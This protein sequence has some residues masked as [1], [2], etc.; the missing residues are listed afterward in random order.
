VRAVNTEAAFGNLNRIGKKY[1]DIDLQKPN[2]TFECNAYEGFRDFI[3]YGFYRNRKEELA[4]RYILHAQEALDKIAPSLPDDPTERVKRLFGRG[5]ELQKQFNN[6]ARK[7]KD[8]HELDRVF[9][10][11]ACDLFIEKLKNDGYNVR[12]FCKRSIEAHELP[13]LHRKLMEIKG[14]GP[15]I[16]SL[17]LRDILLLYSRSRSEPEKFLNELTAE[18]IRAVYPIDTWVGK[19]SKRILDCDGDE[20]QVAETII[21]KCEDFGVSPIYVNHGIF[22]IGAKAQEL[23]LDNLDHLDEFEVKNPTTLASM[24]MHNQT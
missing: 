11:S 9:L 13:E 10:E 17:Y 2:D 20:D 3:R 14:V 4:K 19:I 23:L 15:K 18:E 21:K 16:A 7:N 22:R 6:L 5:K 1:L 8:T 12:H 24:R